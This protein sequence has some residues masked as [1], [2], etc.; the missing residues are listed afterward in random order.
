MEPTSPVQNFSSWP[1]VDQAWASPQ[2]KEGEPFHPR[3][4][5]AD[6]ALCQAIE[7]G[8]CDEEGMLIHPLPEPPLTEEIEQRFFA[9]FHMPMHLLTPSG[10]KSSLLQGG[11][12]SFFQEISC[13]LQALFQV[14][15]SWQCVGSA[16]PWI[17]GKSYFDAFAKE[18]GLATSYVPKEPRDLDVR[19]YLKSERGQNVAELFEP[20]LMAISSIYQQHTG[21]MLKSKQIHA[22]NSPH[23]LN[24]Q[25]TLSQLQFCSPEGRVIELDLLLVKELSHQS[26]FFRNGVALDFEL[27]EISL[28]ALRLSS[29]QKANL[30]VK[31]AGQ[32]LFDRSLGLLNWARG[33]YDLL[34]LPLY[35]NMLASG[36]IVWREG[37]SESLC[38]LFLAGQISLGGDRAGQIAK[39]LH[40]TT[41][42]HLPI[43][44]PYLA[45]TLQSLHDLTE[46]EGREALS[47]AE[48]ERLKKL[49]VQFLEFSFRRFA[50]DP[51][52]SLLFSHFKT[53]SQEQFFSALKWLLFIGSHFEKSGISLRRHRGK[54]C[55]QWRFSHESFIILPA[56]LEEGAFLKKFEQVFPFI[57]SISAL[58]FKNPLKRGA[59]STS[60]QEGPL[61]LKAE[62]LQGSIEALLQIKKPFAHSLAFL[63]GAILAARGYRLPLQAKWLDLAPEALQRSADPKSLLACIELWYQKSRGLSAEAISFSC[64]PLPHAS[65]S[66]EEFTLFW[67][68]SLLKTR[69]QSLVNRVLKEWQKNPSKPL[70]LALL[71]ALPGLDDEKGLALL[72]KI[73]HQ[74]DEEEVWQVWQ[75]FWAARKEDWQGGCTDVL[76]QQLIPLFERRGAAFLVEALFPKDFSFEKL[77]SL[78]LHRLQ[79]RPLFI[80]LLLQASSQGQIAAA[81]LRELSRNHPQLK[82]EILRQCLAE[83][84]PLKALQ[85]IEI[86]D[87]ELF[88]KTT[89]TLLQ[90]NLSDWQLDWLHSLKSWMEQPLKKQ[91]SLISALGPVLSKW[92]WQG[93]IENAHA[94]AALFQGSPGFISLLQEALQQK[95][96]LRSKALSFYREMLKGPWPESLEGEGKLAIWLQLLVK[97]ERDCPNN[98]PELID[99]LSFEHRHLREEVSFFPLWQRLL[100]QEG[101][102]LPLLKSLSFLLLPS[103]L[104]FKALAPLLATAGQ[105]LFLLK[106]FRNLLIA[107][108]Q[109]KE[110]S[111]LLF[112]QA[113]ELLPRIKVHRKEAYGLKLDLIAHGL[114]EQGLPEAIQWIADSSPC[115]INAA[116]LNHIL[117]Q[118]KQVPPPWSNAILL[119]LIK[120]SMALVKEGNPAT[121]TSFLQELDCYREQKLQ[122]LK[123]KSLLAYLSSVWPR[124][125]KRHPPLSELF[126]ETLQREL[127]C[128]SSFVK[129]ALQQIYMQKLLFLFSKQEKSALQAVGAELLKAGVSRL[130]EAS[131]NL[132]EDEIRSFLTFFTE[133]LQAFGSGFSGALGLLNLSLWQRIAHTVIFDLQD[134]LSSLP[135]CDQL[136]LYRAF[137]RQL[138]VEMM[139]TCIEII[140]KLLASAQSDTDTSLAP[141]C[142]LEILFPLVIKRAGPEADQALLIL[143]K[144]LTVKRVCQLKATPP[145][146]LLQTK[147][148]YLLS[149]RRNQGASSLE[150][151]SRAISSNLPLELPSWDPLTELEAT[152]LAIETYL[153]TYSEPMSTAHDM[154]RHM[155][156]INFCFIFIHQYLQ[157]A[158]EQK[159]ALSSDLLF[160]TLFVPVL[161]FNFDEIVDQLNQ[162]RPIFIPCQFGGPTKRACIYEVFPIHFRSF[163]AELKDQHVPELLFGIFEMVMDQLLILLEPALNGS[164]E[165]CQALSDHALE[166]LID[167]I[168]FSSAH[169]LLTPQFPH[170]AFDSLKLLFHL[171][172]SEHLADFNAQLLPSIFHA[173]F[174]KDKDRALLHYL[175]M[176]G[177]IM[178]K[179]G[180]ESY[181]RRIVIKCCQYAITFIK[182]NIDELSQKHELFEQCSMTIPALFELTRQATSLKENA[183]AEVALSQLKEQLC[184][185]AIEHKLSSSSMDG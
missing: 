27:E 68:C 20:F 115:S 174:A 53:L 44:A 55:W 42:D 50:L 158:I 157:K 5:E 146:T 30:P 6:R 89:L 66:L 132:L 127:D 85:L 171:I 40:K 161:T 24:S 144:E 7:Q 37:I 63:Q 33:D 54:P 41:R 122:H 25:Y 74:L 149:K 2:K 179:R 73:G 13:A 116:A 72:Q 153:Q 91:L 70:G 94:L 120:L 139:P 90:S 104:F 87:E 64:L 79:D 31:G 26:L 142:V 119:A 23:T 78:L 34:A 65:A 96:P 35:F 32:A 17:L 28:P 108:Q 46:V 9:L 21:Q 114:T 47:S 93:R 123:K 183:Q 101:A 58:L 51:V 77:F 16:V 113:N 22:N 80:R 59:L 75:L 110:P 124:L 10:K 168:N 15:L 175:Q 48:G 125:K 45:K 169:P 143:E 71:K 140:S 3:E 173:F 118:L 128:D 12:F 138:P 117:E 152:R 52:P 8:L 160:Q 84:Q 62:L 105:E 36:H 60:S 172:Q 181:A 56:Q 1:S 130:K 18:A 133:H 82:R 185:L 111:P 76:Y 92:L 112:M 49:S 164:E 136:A 184:L 121:L 159:T 11:I 135:R 177:Q 81:S 39:S 178:E 106:I 148:F 86:G 162:R 141:F 107:S 14:R 163:Y 166:M 100:Q 180:F 126:I 109:E 134:A 176:L 67:Q 131:P 98:L 165:D 38:S 155:K 154:R 103:K 151:F 19:A 102:S 156:K 69:D 145:L 43:G 4:N 147:V 182:E 97:A 57:E 88:K 61:T 167:A 170:E 83:Q 99:Q 137:F 95:E 29:D 150:T 129:E